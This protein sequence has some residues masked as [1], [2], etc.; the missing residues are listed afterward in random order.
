[1]IVTKYKVSK[2]HAEMTNTGMKTVDLPMV[3]SAML[4]TIWV[5][6]IQKRSCEVFEAIFV[7]LQHTSLPIPV[8]LIGIYVAP[9]CKYTQL[10]H[11]LDE[12]MRNTDD[13]C[14][15]I[16]FGDFNIK[17]VS[18]MHHGYNRKLEQHM[19]DRFGF[20]QVIQQDTSNYS[21]VLDLCFTK[22]K[23]QTSVTWNFWSDHRVVSA[24]L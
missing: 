3:L 6:E 17:S 5:L 14:D 12:L 18:G 4:D 1:M 10:I 23:V 15:T 13:T 8:Q 20:N 21:S 2:L 22:V 16:L 9:K 24:A 7:C 19:K 11:E